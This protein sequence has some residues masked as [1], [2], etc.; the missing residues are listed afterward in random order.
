MVLNDKNLNMIGTAGGILFVLAILVIFVYMV[1]KKFDI[2]EGEKF[3][4]NPNYYTD[5]IKDWKYK[6]ATRNQFKDSAQAAA[7]L[8]CQ[9]R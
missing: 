6:Y 3:E 9:I 8:P 7:E 4:V 1:L 5:F 2:I